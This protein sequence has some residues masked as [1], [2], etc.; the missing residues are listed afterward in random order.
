[1]LVTLLGYAIEE[2]HGAPLSL[3]T[4]VTP[5]EP[6]LVG[7][8]LEQAFSERLDFLGVPDVLG[9]DFSCPVQQGAQLVELS[10]GLLL[11]SNQ[12]VS[13]R[14]TPVAAGCEEN[15]RGPAIY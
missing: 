1:M 12:I 13:G 10:R 11:E 14:H 3:R 4:A 5:E 8:E 7:L 6:F 15:E 9:A 2:Q